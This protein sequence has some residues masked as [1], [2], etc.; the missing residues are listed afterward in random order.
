M[1]LTGLQFLLAKGTEP[2][3][4]LRDEGVLSPYS[5]LCSLGTCGASAWAV[6]AA[7]PSRAAQ[8]PHPWRLGGRLTWRLGVRPAGLLLPSSFRA[9]G[10][11][12][13]G[14]LP[15]THQDVGRTDPGSCPPPP[16]EGWSAKACPSAAAVRVRATVATVA[17]ASPRE[18][19]KIG[20]SIKVQ[21]RL[22]KAS[23]LQG[24]MEL[25]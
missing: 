3:S 23:Q 13:L 21:V 5:P 7:S 9:R 22:S 12:G 1:A 15:G 24:W 18:G 14:F 16:Q 11:L 20:V 19:E 10:A 4:Q 2:S 8:A 17:A 6:T 25:S